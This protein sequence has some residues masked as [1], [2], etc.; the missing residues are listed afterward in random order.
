[1]PSIAQTASGRYCSST[2]TRTTFILFRSD[3]RK[4][5]ER[6]LLAASRERSIFFSMDQTNIIGPLR[7]NMVILVAAFRRAIVFKR[8]ISRWSFHRFR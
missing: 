2:K 7:E 1:M 8:I 4:R 5:G 3:S 6:R